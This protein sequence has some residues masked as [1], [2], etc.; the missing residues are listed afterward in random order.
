MSSLSILT[1]FFNMIEILQKNQPLLRQRSRPILPSVILNPE[2]RTVIKKMTRILDQT[3]D[4]LALAAPQI[5]VLWRL[6]IVSG[7]LF[8]DKQGRQTKNLV[9][10][11]PE[12]KNISKKKR[13]MEEGCL[14]VRWLYGE[15]R[16]AEKITVQ[17]YDE[18]GRKFTCQASGLLAQIF[19]HELDHLNGVLFI[20]KAKKLQEIRP[21]MSFA[22]F[23][24]DEF[25][26]RVL[27]ELRARGIVPRQ[28]ITAPDKPK[29]RHLV[30]TPP[31][32]KIWAQKHS[33]GFLQPEK[34]DEITAKKLRAGSY[35]LFI[36]VAYGKILPP[37]IV[38]MPPHGVLNLH[39][40]LLPKYRG[41]SPIQTAILNGDEETGTTI[42]L[43]DEQIDHGPI[44]KT[45][46]VKLKTQNYLELRDELAKLGAQLLA[47]IIPDWIAGKI[48]PVPQDDTQATY[49]KKILK[50]DGEI[51][52]TDDPELNFRKFRALT[53]WPGIYFFANGTRIKITQAR[54]AD[55][56]FVIEKVIPESKK[57]MSWDAFDRGQK[58]KT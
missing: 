45:Q 23:G 47:E 51:K 25:A 58:L 13:L 48:K 31:P 30:L 44:L 32:V 36:V 49:T 50:E 35:E 2:T 42:M 8:P 14:S 34:L 10:I 28:I 1:R 18:N 9:F 4:G 43:C 40:S 6:F 22:F 16:R 7:K 21:P 20:D 38:Q 53:P 55:S 17:A 39:P 26:V 41:P 54:L 11:N 46:S 19:Q 12:I 33:I 3:A 15:V 24:T 27:E 5:G 37:A 29:G 52:L 57:E 56:K